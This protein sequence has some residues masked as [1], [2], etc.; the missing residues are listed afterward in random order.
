MDG[1]SNVSQ[2]GFALSGSQS[3]ERRTNQTG[4]R[5]ATLILLLALVGHVTTPGHAGSTETEAVLQ[6]ATAAYTEAME[7]RDRDQRLQAFLVAEQLYRQIMAGAD[8]F[9]PV[10]NAPLY[11]NLGNAALQAER[12]GPAIVAYRRALL[13]DPA[14]Q[15]A[16]QNLAYA[17]AVLP[18]WSRVESASGLADTLFVWRAIYSRP[19]ILSLAAVCFLGAASLL[20]ASFIRRQPLWRH[21]AIVPSLG[22]LVLVASIAAGHND[23]LETEAV[24][25]SHELVMHAA[26]SENSPRRLSSPLPSGAEVRIIR[27]R[28]QWAEIE[29]SGGRTGWVLNS[30]LERVILRPTSAVSN[31]D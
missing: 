28:E 26:D 5:L 2:R 13:L 31:L 29:V 25:I 27:E 12:I 9:A 18:E 20:S 16:R 1:V 14:H 22:W 4:R 11:V 21:L 3:S 24:V 30:G 6:R 10:H 7:I 23:R 15:Q 19:Q 8:Q 17:R